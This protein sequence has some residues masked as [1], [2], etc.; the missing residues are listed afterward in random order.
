M[1]S[2][3]CRF[4]ALLP[5]LLLGACTADAPL[6]ESTAKTSS[7]SR[8][9]VWDDLTL[10][11]NDIVRVGVYGHPELGTPISTGINGT[12][13][14]NQGLLS[15]PLVGS[16]PV[17]GKSVQEARALVTEAV[18]KYVQEPKVDLSV[19]EYGARRVYIYGEVHK[20]GAYV[21]DRPMNVYQ[22]L[23]LGGGFTAGARREQIV[24]LRGRP[25]AL[26]VKVVD[27]D[28]PNIEGLFALRPDDFVF[29]RRSGAG[30]FSDEVLPILA[31]ISSA[32]GSAATILVLNDQLK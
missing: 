11:P 28:T 18:A 10:G 27:G 31:G 25:E 14:D 19:A 3:R 2:L 21:L 5:A 16:V 23:T 32:L 24:V 1:H 17:G 26:E 8:E 12:R 15:L 22:A 13:I 6:P 7:F 29:V 30:K 4:L 20:P 9:L